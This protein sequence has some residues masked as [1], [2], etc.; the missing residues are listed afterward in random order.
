MYQSIRSHL[1]PPEEPI[2]GFCAVL[3]M[4]GKSGGGNGRV[5]GQ[6]GHANKHTLSKENTFPVGFF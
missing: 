5:V 2:A 1:V 4:C 3:S 6:L